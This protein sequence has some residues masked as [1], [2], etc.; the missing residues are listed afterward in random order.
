MTY[1]EAGVLV[2]YQSAIRKGNNVGIQTGA[3]SW[4]GLAPG[5][6]SNSRADELMSNRLSSH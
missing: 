5:T 4:H 6:W 2:S 3:R 1:I